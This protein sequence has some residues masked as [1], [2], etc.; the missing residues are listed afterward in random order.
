MSSPPTSPKPASDAHSSNHTDE[1]ELLARAQQRFL[2]GNY[3]EAGKIAERLSKSADAHVAGEAK[4]ILTR[5]SPAPLARYL[6]AL[7]FVLLLVVTA[8]AYSRT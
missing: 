6:L 8:F 5:L 3:L 1:S 4:Q 7:T 2:D